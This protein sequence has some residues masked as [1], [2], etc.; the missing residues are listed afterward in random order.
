M[1]H[2]LSPINLEQALDQYRADL[3][4]FFKGRFGPSWHRRLL[5]YEC[6]P[7][8]LR[9]KRLPQS[10]SALRSLERVA[11]GLGFRPYVG[12]VPSPFERN[13][14]EYWPRLV[15]SLSQASYVPSCVPKVSKIC[16]LWMPARSQDRRRSDVLGKPLSPSPCGCN[17]GNGIH[18]PMPATFDAKQAMEEPVIVNAMQESCHRTGGQTTPADFAQ[19]S[20]R[21]IKSPSRDE[22]SG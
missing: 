6:S 21:A 16:A 15:R 2:R 20:P 17:V 22:N 19:S 10:I 12:R 11:I 4:Q 3:L 13:S 1:P 9:G 14:R 8:Y 7:D 18:S 5:R